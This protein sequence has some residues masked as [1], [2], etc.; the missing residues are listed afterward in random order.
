[1]IINL[2]VL[3]VL[4]IHPPPVLHYPR[5]DRAPEASH[6]TAVHSNN[7]IVHSNNAIV[8]SVYKRFCFGYTVNILAYSLLER[9]LRD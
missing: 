9:D 8:W 1:M 7:A 6:C 2:L 3:R 5:L 4:C